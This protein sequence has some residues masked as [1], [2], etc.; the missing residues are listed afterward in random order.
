MRQTV[1]GCAHLV[2]S[3]QPLAAWQLMLLQAKG[4][5]PLLG[6]FPPQGYIRKDGFVVV[7]D[8]G[9]IAAARQ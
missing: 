4:V 1:V 8:W 6:L 2:G 5:V 7:L 9:L 3:R